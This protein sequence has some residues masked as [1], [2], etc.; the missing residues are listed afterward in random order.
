MDP[1]DRFAKDHAID[2]NRAIMIQIEGGSP[3][4]T[5]TDQGTLNQKSAF[6]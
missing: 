5:G 2:L 3:R 4:S 6:D 1:V